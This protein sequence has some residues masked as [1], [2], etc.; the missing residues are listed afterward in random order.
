METGG[1]KSVIF[2]A[3]A[4][5]LGIAVAKF[6]AAAWTQSSAML[7]E[8]IHSLVDTSNQLLLLFGISRAARPADAQHPFGHGKEIYF[9][10]FIVAMVLFALGAGVAI[11]EGIEKILDPHPLHDVYVVYVVLVIAMALEGYSTLKAI[12]EF[13]KRRRPSGLGFVAALRASKDPSLFAIVLEDTAAMLGLTIALIGTMVADFGGY[14]QADGI[15]SILIGCVLGFVAIFMSSEIRSLIVG[16]SAS[17]AV[18][19]GLREIIALEAGADKPIRAINEIRTMHLGPQ[20]V[21][22]TASVDFEDW[23]SARTVEDV[24]GRLQQAIKSRYPEVRHLFIE[25]QSEKAFQA[26][27]SSSALLGAGNSAH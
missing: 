25:V 23:V 12:G 8:A 7:S 3:F 9:W 16:E 24:T 13:N 4:C 11:Y 5:N 22:V 17:P 10:S 20:D 15:A 19:S 18:Q 6:M 1:S 2:I 26:N 21:L 27:K 14:E